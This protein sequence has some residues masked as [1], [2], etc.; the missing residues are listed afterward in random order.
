MLS[1]A[2]IWGAFLTNVDSCACERAPRGVYV[3]ALLPGVTKTNFHEASGGTADQQPPAAITQTVAEVVDTLS[4]A[5]VPG[6]VLFVGVSES[7]FRIGTQLIC[8]ERDRVFFYRKP[9]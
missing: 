2:I 5:L 4:R 7:L 9:T 8:E 3:A 6:G 1:S